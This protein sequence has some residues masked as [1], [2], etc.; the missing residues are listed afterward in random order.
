MIN[1]YTNYQFN[2]VSGYAVRRRQ[3]ISVNS[4]RSYPWQLIN[5]QNKWIGSIPLAFLSDTDAD[6]SGVSSRYDTTSGLPPQQAWCKGK[7]LFTSPQSND[8][9]TLTIFPYWEWLDIFG[10]DMHLYYKNITWYKAYYEKLWYG[11]RCH[12]IYLLI[13]KF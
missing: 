5:S 6:D 10:F 2:T 1:L 11:R 4:G 8:S 3:I 13:Q 9:D 12:Q 7:F